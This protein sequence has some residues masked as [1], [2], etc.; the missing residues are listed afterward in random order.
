MQYPLEAL[1][2]STEQP[3][4]IGRDPATK[5]F[6]VQVAGDPRRFHVTATLGEREFI[7]ALQSIC[8]DA[9]R[10]RSGKAP[11][12]GSLPLRPLWLVGVDCPPAPSSEPVAVA[13]KFTVERAT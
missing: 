4:T 10:V 3:I 9:A 13:F 7:A 8:S 1:F 6:V 11:K 12:L 2:Y 5:S